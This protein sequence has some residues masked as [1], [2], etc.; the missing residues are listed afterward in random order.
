MALM[1]S[2][3]SVHNA[4]AMGPSSPADDGPSPPRV[5]T[6]PLIRRRLRSAPSKR[7]AVVTFPAVSLFVFTFQSCYS[8]GHSGTHWAYPKHSTRF[9]HLNG[10][11]T[12]VYVHESII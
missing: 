11:T 10:E 5:S 1:L 4:S 7:G 6:L 12:E 9:H 2:D 3:R 8:R